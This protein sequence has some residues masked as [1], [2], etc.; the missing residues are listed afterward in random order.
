MAISA[1]C[2]ASVAMSVF[3]FISQITFLIKR[4]SLH[5]AIPESLGGPYSSLYSYGTWHGAWHTGGNQI[6]FSELKGNLHAI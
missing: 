4:S 2:H 5:R 3:Y 1:V 6:R